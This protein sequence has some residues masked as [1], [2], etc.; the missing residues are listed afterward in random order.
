MSQSAPLTPANVSSR[1][2]LAGRYQTTLQLL[3]STSRYTDEWFR[4]KEEEVALRIDLAVEDSSV[5]VMPENDAELRISGDFNEYDRIGPDERPTIVSDE[6]HPISP[7]EDHFDKTTKLESTLPVA[8]SHEGDVTPIPIIQSSSLYVDDEITRKIKIAGH[9]KKKN[10]VVAVEDSNTALL[11]REIS[12]LAHVPS[13]ARG[14]RN[15]LHSSAPNIRSAALLARTSSGSLSQLAPDD[16]PS[17]PYTADPSGTFSEAP[18]RPFSHQIDFEGEVEE[19]EEEI[20]TIP[21]AFLVQETI[22]LPLADFVESVERPDHA[23][24]LSIKR[25]VCVLTLFVVALFAIALGSALYVTFGRTSLASSAQPPGTAETGSEFFE[26]SLEPSYYPSPHPS[27]MTIQDH[28]E[29]YVLQRNVSFDGMSALDPRKLALDWITKT[30]PL[31]LDVS[32]A[33]LHQRYVLALLVYECSKDKDLAWLSDN[34]ECEWPGVT[35]KYGNVTKVELGGKALTGTIPPEIVRLEYLQVLDVHSNSLS[36]TLPAELE[37]GALPL[38]TTIDL[39]FNNFTGTLPAELGNA[40]ALTAIYMMRNNF[41]G[42]IP[43]EIGKLSALE[44]I[45]L[46]QNDLYGTI[47]RELGDLNGLTL[48]YLNS[49]SLSGSLPSEIAGLHSLKIMDMS[50]NSLFGTLPPE[51]GHL[52]ELT[53]LQIQA[54]AFNGTLPSELGNL[55]Q[56]TEFAFYGNKFTGSLPSD[57]GN[58]SNL[59][60]LFASTNQLTGTLPSEIGLLQNLQELSVGINFLNGTLPSELGNLKNLY[61]LGLDNNRFAGILPTELNELRSLTHLRLNGNQFIGPYLSGLGTC[62]TGMSVLC[63]ESS[64]NFTGDLPEECDLYGLNCWDVSTL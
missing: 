62:S 10:N 44:V 55:V 36:G 47:P 23:T 3:S 46:A 41:T 32:D 42:P 27:L 28:I 20:I 60:K 11:D 14:N 33:H 9:N 6:G 8:L 16:A 2:S 43:K 52:K 53:S 35:C 5:S 26:P 59:L 56:L 45:Y 54:N 31:Q 50:L 12:E 19:R 63:V 49:N 13:S 1:G 38:L 51:L 61:H 24:M 40:S 39:G 17:T 7:L 15:M 64:N 34:N 22:D 57:I 30:D 4:L 21:E 48:I 58:L 37:I 18:S 29:K 25:R